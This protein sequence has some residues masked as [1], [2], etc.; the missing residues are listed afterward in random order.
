[1]AALTPKLGID[2]LVTVIIQSE[3]YL[4]PCQRSLINILHKR[5]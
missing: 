1:M 4:G 2:E 5:S 3:A